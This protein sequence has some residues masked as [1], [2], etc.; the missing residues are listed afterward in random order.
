[1]TIRLSHLAILLALSTLI[2]AIG[3]VAATWWIADKEFRDVLGDDLEN[4][5]KLLAELVTSDGFN[6]TDRA[7]EKQLADAFENDDEE[8]LWVTVYNRRDGTFVS[9]LDHDLPLDGK[10]DGSIRLD[11][12]GYSW[13]GYREEE[14]HFI[15]QLMRRDDLYAEVQG[16]IL[17]D[18][19]TPALIGSGINLLL[20]ALL[21]AFFLWPMTRLARQLETR[22]A[23]SLEPIDVRTP[24][25][26]IRLLRD[27]LNKLMKNVDS[28]LARERQFASD[29]AHELRTPLTTLKLELSGGDPDVAV[30]KSEVDRVSRLVEQLLTLARLEQGQWQQRFESVSLT[31]TVG[32]A[33]GR[34]AGK[35]RSAGMTLAS[36]GSAFNI[37]GDATLLDM[38]V[39]NLLQNV[40][41][42]CPP[43]T[44]AD[45]LLDG[46]PAGVRMRVSDNG[47]GIAGDTRRQMAQGFRQLD[48]KSE[49]LGMGLAIC[50]RIAEVHGAAIS[51]PAREDGG[52]GLVVEVIFS[53]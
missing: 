35:F 49:G 47:P 28:V 36:R 32:R 4:Q 22:S 1:M 11:Y 9:N 48:S 41:V 10:D 38:L 26:E 53:A 34:F 45:V 33:V 40:L 37:K 20:L 50:H 7:L 6:L 3:G 23:T 17:E 52:S 42:H 46:M 39:Q 15:V 12:D 27:S 51:F 24:A 29:V 30:V 21:I 5:S 8:T 43:G 31:D 44:H 16:E 14:D 18:I 25:R 2:T 19:I 13:H